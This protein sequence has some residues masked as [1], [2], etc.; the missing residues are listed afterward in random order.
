MA[1]TMKGR[2]RSNL[3]VLICKHACTGSSQISMSFD[4]SG[5]SSASSRRANGST[6]NPSSGFSH[7]SVISDCQHSVTSSRTSGNKRSAAKSSAH[8]QG[9]TRST[10]TST[11]VNAH[12]IGDDDDFGDDNKPRKRGDME[13]QLGEEALASSDSDDDSDDAS[14]TFDITRTHDVTAS[15]KRDMELEEM[16]HRLMRPTIASR[17]RSAPTDS[18][19]KRLQEA[20]MRK[21]QQTK[22]RSVTFSTSPVVDTSKRFLGVRTVSRDQMLDIVDRLHPEDNSEHMNSKQKLADEMKAK[23]GILNS[24]YCIGEWKYAKLHRVCP[25]ATQ[26]VIDNCRDRLNKFG[27]S[28]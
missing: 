4:Q 18:Q 15:S 1:V 24:Y 13:L 2:F 6:S 26:I 5:R 16:S 22:T 7:Q 17:A 23:C 8:S 11:R 19:R 3:P 20:I 9:T 14:S 28:K 10:N 21:R 25:L 12:R 27:P